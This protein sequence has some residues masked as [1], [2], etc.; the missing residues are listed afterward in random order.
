MQASFG[1]PRRKCTGKYNFQ[2]SKLYVFYG[3]GC[4]R[5]TKQ[6]QPCIVVHVYIGL[7][8]QDLP[9]LALERR[10]W[11]QFGELPYS[12]RSSRVTHFVAFHYFSL[13]RSSW[14]IIIFPTCRCRQSRRCACWCHGLQ[15]IIRYVNRAQDGEVRIYI[16]RVYKSINQSGFPQDFVISPRGKRHPGEIWRKTSQKPGGAVKLQGAFCHWHA[17]RTTL[18]FCRT[19]CLRE[20]FPGMAN[21]PKKMT[22]KDVFKVCHDDLWQRTLPISC[23]KNVLLRQDPSTDELGRRTHWFFREGSRS[24]KSVLKFSVFSFFFFFPG[25]DDWHEKSLPYIV[26]R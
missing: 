14:S 3:N 19:V 20:G 6:V 10:K 2:V 17:G 23:H 26:H 16:R 15:H 7:R 12:P 21:E 4:T 1:L 25:D 8:L 24:W 22:R 18:K 9:Q 11:K 13:W 5:S